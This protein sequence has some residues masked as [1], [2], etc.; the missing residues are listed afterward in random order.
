VSASAFVRVPQGEHNA[1]LFSLNYSSNSE[2]LNGIPIPG[3]AY[4]YAPSDWFQATVGIPFA[5]ATIR[6]TDDLTLQISYALLTTVHARA[7][8]RVLPPVRVY[9]GFDTMVESYYRVGR[10]DDRDR[11]FYYDKRVAG[12]LQWFLSR[13]TSLDLSAGYSFDRFY[14]E[15]RR[16]T[17]RDFNRIDVGAGPFAGLRVDVH[18]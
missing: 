1:W 4:F 2:V 11:F 14:F 18:F 9:A 12:G 5:S 3:V 16:F 6:P 15:G 13:Q 8:Y 7:I 10:L 17:A